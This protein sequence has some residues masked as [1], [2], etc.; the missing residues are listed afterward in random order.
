MISLFLISLSK[1]FHTALAFKEASA[2]DALSSQIFSAKYAKY[3]FTQET[4]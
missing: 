4:F 3:H 1:L 2:V